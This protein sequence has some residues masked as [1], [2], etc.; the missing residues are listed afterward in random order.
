MRI[1]LAEDSVL[2][3][4]GLVV[5]LERARHEVVA[6]FATAD[7]VRHRL[8][9]DDAD[10][11]DLLISDVRMLPEETDDGLRAAVSIRQRHPA[12]PVLLLSQWLGSEYLL[13]LMSM[14]RSDPS[15]GGVG[16]LLKDRIAH[17][18]D[19]I[20]AVDAV[21]G[22]GIVVDRQVIAGLM[23]QRDVGLSSLTPREQSVLQ[24]VSA[25]ATNQQISAQ[26]H[27]SEGAVVKHISSIFDKLGLSSEEGNRR[28][29]AVLTY[30]GRRH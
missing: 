3:R 27:L 18:R 10:L 14:V 11:P 26:L 8:D 28:V 22:G 5:L 9:R 12:L 4:D 25:G 24:L 15:S 13:R 17:V 1:M 21:A 19:F 30:L 29:L 20:G 7:E 6:Q 23:D 2:M 16:Y